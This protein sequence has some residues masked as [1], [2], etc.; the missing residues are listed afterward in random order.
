MKALHLGILCALALSGLLRAD[1]VAINGFKAYDSYFK[2]PYT[3]FPAPQTR[4]ELPMKDLVVGVVLQA[5]A[6]AEAVNALA[7]KREAIYREDPLEVTVK[8]DPVSRLA[9]ATDVNG[10]VIPSVMV[11][12]FAWQAFHPQTVVWN[13]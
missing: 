11:F 9:V 4:D 7:E 10:R 12:W 2:S 13:P 8:Y 3:M 6:L 1:D 5:K